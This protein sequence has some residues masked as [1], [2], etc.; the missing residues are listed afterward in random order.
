MRKQ[1]IEKF[2]MLSAEQRLE[3]ALNTG[4]EINRALSPKAK[5]IQEICRN[6]GKQLLRSRMDDHSK[7]NG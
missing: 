5:K 6:G 7:D 3:W 4:W 1:H 2:Q